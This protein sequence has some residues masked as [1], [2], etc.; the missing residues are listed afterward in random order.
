MVDGEDLIY[1]SGSG[2]VTG[3]VGLRIPHANSLSG[4]RVLHGELLRCHDSE[5]DPRVNLEACRQVGS[6][7]APITPVS[8]PIVELT[9]GKV[10]GY[11]G[12]G[13]FPKDVPSP[14]TTGT[15]ALISA[16]GS[17]IALWPPGSSPRTDITWP[18]RLLPARSRH[19]QGRW[20]T[21]V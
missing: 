18:S 13:R 15:I 12:L 21:W 19:W 17:G 16:G 3:H 9:S 20:M 2:S 1:W 11:E 5:S 6:R 7:S 14:M 10:A 4:L 8:Q